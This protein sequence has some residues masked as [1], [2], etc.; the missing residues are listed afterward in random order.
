MRL[1]PCLLMTRDSGHLSGYGKCLQQYS[2]GCDACTGAAVC[3]GSAADG[4]VGGKGTPLHIVGAPEGTPP[5]SSQ[6]EVRQGDPLG[7][8]L[9]A[10]MLNHV[11]E[12]VDA[13]CEEA[14]LA[15]CVISDDMRIVGKLTPAAGAFR[16]LCV[17]ENGVRSIG[18]CCDSQSLASTSVTRRR[19]PS[20]LLT[21]RSRTSSMASPRLAR[22]WGQR[23]LF[24]TPWGGMQ[25]QW[26][27]WWTHWSSYHFLYSP[28]YCFCVLNC[29]H[30]YCAPHADS[31]FRG[32]G[33]V[34]AQHGR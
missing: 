33:D 8:L 20:W 17:D 24:Q 7:P 31:A 19:S 15:S 4:I 16:Q 22:L 1:R 29:K 34:H 10:L 28:R 9:F 25:R 18:S 6:R 13:A 27:C 26:R 30:T 11:L 12:R 21:Y 14:M 5:I 2:S 32:A 3:T 23:S